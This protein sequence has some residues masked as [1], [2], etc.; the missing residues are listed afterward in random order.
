MTVRADHIRASTLTRVIGQV[1]DAFDAIGDATP[2][3]VG[4]QHADQGG[5]APRVVFIPEGGSSRFEHPQEIGNALCCVHSCIVN[6][7]APETGDELT[8]LDLTYALMDRVASIIQTAAPGRIEWSEMACDSPSGVDV[9]GAGLSF[10]FSYRRDISHDVA[11]WSLPP[12]AEDASADE[13]SPPPGTPVGGVS[14]TAT[15]SPKE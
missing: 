6:V 5:C 11:R 4:K 1:R 10:R 12:S 9:F 7:R 15:V 14:V 13:A 3:L 8:R 2:V